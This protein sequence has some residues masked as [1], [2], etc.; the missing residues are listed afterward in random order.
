MATYKEAIR[1][2]VQNDD[3]T[4]L[5]DRSG[6]LSTSGCLVA[7]IFKKTDEQVLKDIERTGLKLLGKEGL[8]KIKN[9]LPIWCRKDEML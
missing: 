2:I 5:Y 4:F 6:G 3:L 1:W 8:E 9:S 7:D